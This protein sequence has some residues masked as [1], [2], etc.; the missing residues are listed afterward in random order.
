MIV[1]VVTHNSNYQRSERSTLTFNIKHY[2]GGAFLLC[3]FKLSCVH[4][5]EKFLLPQLEYQARCTQI[6][7]PPPCKYFSANAT[8][9]TYGN[10]SSQS[11]TANMC[12]S[13]LH[14]FHDRWVRTRSV[15]YKYPPDGWPVPSGS[16]WSVLGSVRTTRYMRLDTG[17]R[18][19]QRT[20]P[21]HPHLRHGYWKRHA[22]R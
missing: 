22:A 16:W 10:I 17:L 7:E 11:C 3:P 8:L 4:F 21:E 14:W 13:Q 6:S 1:P 12:S 5:D 2:R 9:S 19:C 15:A 20:S 18:M